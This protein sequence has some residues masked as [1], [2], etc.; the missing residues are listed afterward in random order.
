MLCA[1]FNGDGCIC[2]YLSFP[3]PDNSA[4]P[5][6]GRDAREIAGGV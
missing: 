5:R 3:F 2:T 4:H 6:P 1:R